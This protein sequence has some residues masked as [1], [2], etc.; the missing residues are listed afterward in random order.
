MKVGGRAFGAE[1]V[2]EDR[3]EG[4]E[5]PGAQ[6]QP[7]LRLFGKQGIRWEVL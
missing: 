5:A 7:V 4:R 6:G 2:T 1:E 3:H